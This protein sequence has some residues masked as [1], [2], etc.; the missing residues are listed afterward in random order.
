MSDQEWSPTP[1]LRWLVSP[2]LGERDTL[3]QLWTKPSDYEGEQDDEEWREV[4]RV[5]WSLARQ[6]G[7]S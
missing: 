1:R 7:W 6:R 2:T 4:E 3:Q 5:E